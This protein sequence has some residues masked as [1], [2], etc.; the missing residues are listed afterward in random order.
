MFAANKGC[1]GRRRI[2]DELA[3]SATIV[4]ERVI[5]AIMSEEGLVA[6]GSKRKKRYYSSYKGEI[7]EH[8]GNKV[9]RDFRSALPNFL[10]PAAVTQFSIPAGKVYLSPIINCFDG[11]VVSYTLST[12][13]DAERCDLDVEA[14]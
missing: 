6:K 1:Y 9:N 4:A 5:S 7:S 3:D 8:P 2:H 12:S 11:L 13:P 14:L 10:W